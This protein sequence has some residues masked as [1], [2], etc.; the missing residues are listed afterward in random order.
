MPGENTTHL[1]E[2]LERVPVYQGP[3]TKAMQFYVPLT[4]FAVECIALLAFFRFFQFWALLFVLPI[5]LLLMMKTA[6][7]QW[8][9]EN[10]AC[11]FQKKAFVK[12]KGVRGKNVVSFTPHI[13]RHELRAEIGHLRSQKGKKNA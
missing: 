11:N 12:N 5:H 4:V 7:D 1:E 3:Q 10:L 2:P 9:V 8:W 13:S 6:S